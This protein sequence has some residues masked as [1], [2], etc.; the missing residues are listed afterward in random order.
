LE[1]LA[2]GLVD[3]TAPIAKRTRSIFLLRQLGGIAAIEA[4]A[5]GLT[6]PSVLLAHECAYN[7][8]QLKD[9]RANPMLTQTLQN[10][11][12]DVIVR[13]EAAEALGAIG[14]PTSLPVLQQYLKDAHPEISETCAI[15]V[16]RIEWFQQQKSGSS[17]APG[18]G[19]TRFMS[20]DPAPALP[21]RETPLLQ[22][23]LTDPSQSLFQRYR[24]MFAL[25]NRGDAEAV[26]A[27]ATGFND[28]SALFRHEIAYVMGQLQHPAAVPS[29]TQR[30]ED[31]KE[32]PM[33]RHEA[34]EAL[35]AIG[36]DPTAPVLTRYQNDTD[37]IVRESCSVALDIS[38]YWNSNEFESVHDGIEDDAD[39]KKE[40]KNSRLAS[41]ASSQHSLVKHE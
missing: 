36:T 39:E 35:G 18:A 41:T 40:Q 20:I 7:L 31:K 13:H 6:S 34:A 30:L 22:K 14:S 10:S 37:R 9:D 12:L 23:V 29:L 33:V 32:H 28:H 11:K 5:A 4:L 24:A 27:L 17:E 8:G 25:R 19:S 16:Q 38:E 3:E 2:R 26:L 15:A 21:D 1:G